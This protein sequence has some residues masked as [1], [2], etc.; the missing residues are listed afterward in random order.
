[1]DAK[2]ALGAFAE[3][4]GMAYFTHRRNDGVDKAESE[5]DKYY[6][7]LAVL[8]A[9]VEELEKAE[10]EVEELKDD[11]LDARGDSASDKAQAESFAK[12]NNDAL[13]KLAR[14]RPL[15]EAAGKAVLPE[16]GKEQFGAVFMWETDEDTILRAALACRA[17]EG[18]AD[19]AIRT[20][21]IREQAFLDRLDGADEDPRP[22]ADDETP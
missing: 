14:W 6:A 10:A 18:K 15:I 4:M 13:A 16:E 22:P 5:A 17:E 12:L 11:L 2:K 1:M 9:A 21:H 20:E 7:A 8:T 19:S 3:A